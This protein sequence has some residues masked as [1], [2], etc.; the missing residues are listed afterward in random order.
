MTAAIRRPSPAR[1]WL[2]RLTKAANV[3]LSGAL[4]RVFY[5][6][7]RCVVGPRRKVIEARQRELPVVT[8]STDG[9]FQVETHQGAQCST[10]GI[11]RFSRRPV[12]RL[13]PAVPL[14]ASATPSASPS[15]VIVGKTMDGDAAR[16]RSISSK[17]GSPS[18]SRNRCRYECESL[19][20]RNQDS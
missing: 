9:R 20:R 2:R 11:T 15:R 8:T 14:L 10:S 1:M 3:A 16:E 6:G 7:C 18:T 5:C 4:C 19:H 13:S 17:S 12:N